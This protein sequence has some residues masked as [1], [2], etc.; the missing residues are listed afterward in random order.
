[1]IDEYEDDMAAERALLDRVEE[2]QAQEEAELGP[3]SLETSPRKGGR[4]T[5]VDPIKLVAWR[6]ARKATVAATAK[7][8]KVSERTVQ[9]YSRD[10]AEAALAERKRWEIEKLDRELQ[11]HENDRQLMYHRM[12]QEHLS[13]VGLEWFSKCEAARG[14]D[15][16]EAV[17]AARDAALEEADRRFAED[18]DRVMGPT[19]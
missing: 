3:A 5:K 7:H 12:R 17:E 15:Q 18:W 2:L 16:E 4:P 13:W 14:T 19:P 10:Y 9:Q 6:Q 1:V 11:H 8:W